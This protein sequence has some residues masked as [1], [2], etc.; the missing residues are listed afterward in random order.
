MTKRF[1]DSKGTEYDVID[2]SMDDSAADMVRGLGYQQAP[3]VMTADGRHWGGFQP[4]KLTN[5]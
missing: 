3:V 4:D 1:L 2:M 5:I